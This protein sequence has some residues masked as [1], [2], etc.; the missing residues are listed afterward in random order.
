MRLFG[1]HEIAVGD[2]PSWLSD[3]LTGVQWPAPSAHWTQA[4]EFAAPF[5]VKHLWDGGRFL[6]APPAAATAQD[7]RAP[8]WLDRW[9]RDFLAVNPPNQGPHW[10]CAQEAGLRLL[11]ALLAAQLLGQDR[12][13][14]PGLVAMAE[15]HLARILPTTGYAQAQDNNHVI[16]EAA[17]LFAGGVFL[18]AADPTARNFAERCARAGRRSLERAAARLIAP[19]GGFALRSFNYMREV[20]DLLSFV[21]LWRRSRGLAA[22]SSV[23]RGRAAAMAHLL[24]QVSDPETGRV[25]VLGPDD[26]SLLFATEAADPDDF[27]PSIQL[28][29]TLFAGA[30]PFPPGRWDAERQRRALA[31]PSR[32]MM[33]QSGLF[34]QT[35]LA[36]AVTAQGAFILL[37]VPAG[38]FR[39][40]QADGLHVEVWDGALAVARDAGSR[41]YRLSDEE[42]NALAGAGGHNT[43]SFD[44]EEPM[45][46]LGRFLYGGWQERLELDL[47]LEPGAVRLTGALR[48]WKGRTHHREVRV[49]GRRIEVAD[50]VD[51]SYGEASLN[52]RL[53]KGPWRPDGRFA[54]T[55]GKRRITVAAPGGAWSDWV[56]AP[57]QHGYGPAVSG[58]ASRLT[59]AFARPGA[60]PA[61][62]HTTLELGE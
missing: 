30:G 26:G 4:A 39:P 47:R 41:A 15:T 24:F 53:V 10:R 46:R 43:I 16:A 14:E 44:G 58:E 25:P 55:D 31:D 36:T 11:H 22:F 12:T 40:V 2:P 19:D 27:R 5:D 29:R 56:D 57:E 18:A 45:P 3:P 59:V 9:V 20:L 32:P 38:R 21:E 60:G 34:P 62:L 52:W 48:D 7:G 33:R 42:Q 28:A 49:T 35:G 51:G 23:F 6:W 17:A 1:R 50:R 8:V 37:A 61:I 13:P 54:W